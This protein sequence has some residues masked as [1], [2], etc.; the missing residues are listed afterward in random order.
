MCTRAQST[1]AKYMSRFVFASR[2]QGGAV[3]PP[4]AKS[5][6]WDG[7]GG[8]LFFVQASGLWVAVGPRAIGAAAFRKVGALPITIVPKVILRSRGASRAA[9]PP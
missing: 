2:V 4:K 5:S 1:L 8:S 3:G 9:E 6:I 7:F